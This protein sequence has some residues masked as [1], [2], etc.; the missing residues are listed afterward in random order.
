[1]QK[2]QIH[3]MMKSFPEIIKNLPEADI[4]IEG[5]KAYISQADSHQ[6]LFMEL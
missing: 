1:M 6:I 4:P 3:D 2:K 5:V